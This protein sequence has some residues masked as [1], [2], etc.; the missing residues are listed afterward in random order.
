MHGNL[1]DPNPRQYRAAARAKPIARV[2]AKSLRQ[3]MSQPERLLW[4]RLRKSQLAGLRF[5]KQHPIGPFIADFYCHDARLVVEIDGPTHAGARAL[6][7]VKRDEWMHAGARALDDV[8][9]DEW[10]HARGVR[11]LR[12]PSP[13]V[14]SNLHGV[15]STIALVAKRSAAERSADRTP[16]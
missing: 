14:F 11:V 3:D 2:R 10:M 9:R 12:I 15:L 13:E 8:K 7:D 1:P 16:S 4:S 5:R 6:D